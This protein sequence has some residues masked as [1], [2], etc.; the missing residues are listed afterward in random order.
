M[1]FLSSFIINFHIFYQLKDIDINGEPT[2]YFEINESQKINSLQDLSESDNKYFEDID[3][4]DASSELHEKS[5]LATIE[6][7]I[8]GIHMLYFIYS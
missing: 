3:N 6:Q 2:V 1:N 4:L 7:F 5:A 8:L